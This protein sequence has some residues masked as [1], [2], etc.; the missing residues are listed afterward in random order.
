[1]AGDTKGALA[2]LKKAIEMAP[3]EV[4]RETAKDP[5]FEKLR[6]NEEFKNLMK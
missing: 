5:A 2:D 3:V 1:M 6:D 4:K